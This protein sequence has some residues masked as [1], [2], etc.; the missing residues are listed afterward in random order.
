M[1]QWVQVAGYA[2]DLQ[3]AY[4]YFLSRGGP[5]AAARFFSRYERCVSSIVAHPESNA[6]RRHGGVR[7]RFRT[8]PSA[9]FMASVM[10]SGCLWE[11]KAP[12]ATRTGFRRC[13]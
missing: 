13:F 11:F 6:V 2:G 4:D 10:R 3:A 7:S 8:Q 9:F 5:L 1:T 12:S